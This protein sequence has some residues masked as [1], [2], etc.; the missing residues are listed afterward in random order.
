MRKIFET[1]D[2]RRGKARDRYRRVLCGAAFFA[3]AIYIALGGFAQARNVAGGDAAQ[4]V[5]RVGQ[6][7]IDVLGA[8]EQAIDQRRRNFRTIFNR[9]LDLDGMARRA[10]GRHWRRATEP[11]KKQYV[12]LFRRYVLGIYAVQLGGH[13]SETF[14]VLRQQPTSPTESLV[15]ARITRKFGA[16]LNLNFRVRM[17]GEN[18]RIIDVTVAGVSLIVTKRSEFNSIIRREGLP[19]LLRRLDSKSTAGAMPAASSGSLLAKSLSELSSGSVLIV[20]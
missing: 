2:N 12:R 5:A 4:F 16:P 20:R 18:H 13:A 1:G 19:G 8:P 3:G 11:Q 6:G 9:A 10:L 17:T 15:I 7:V 14:K